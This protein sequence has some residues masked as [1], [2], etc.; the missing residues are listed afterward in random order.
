MR[1]TTRP[2]QQLLMVRLFSTDKRIQCLYLYDEAC[3]P[4]AESGGK[5]VDL[6][7]QF[8]SSAGVGRLSFYLRQ[9]PL[10]QD[11]SLSEDLQM[12]V[13]KQSQLKWWGLGMSSRYEWQMGAVKNLIQGD[14]VRCASKIDEVDGAYHNTVEEYNR[15]LQE[16]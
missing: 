16:M 8:S 5:S 6:S 2:L 9:S 14:T 4:Y 1:I 12:Q 10:F 3:L 7:E 13:S 15:K 11:S